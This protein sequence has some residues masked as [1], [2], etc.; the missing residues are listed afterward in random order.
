VPL[1]TEAGCEGSSRAEKI[2]G[3]APGRFAYAA[4]AESEG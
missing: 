1:F 2:P 4:T 3:W